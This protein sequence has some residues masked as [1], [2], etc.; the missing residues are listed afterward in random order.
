MEW[1]EKGHEEKQGDNYLSGV[2]KATG[3]P[4]DTRISNNCLLITAIFPSCLFLIASVGV[5]SVGPLHWPGR[6]CLQR[7]PGSVPVILPCGEERDMSG[8]AGT[9]GLPSG[10]RAITTA[11]V[12]PQNQSV[13]RPVLHPNLS[14]AAPGKA[15]A[16]GV[17]CPE[18]LSARLSAGRDKPGVFLERLISAEPK[19]IPG[20]ALAAGYGHDGGGHGPSGWQPA[21]SLTQCPARGHRYG[22]RCS[23][24]QTAG[25]AAPGE[26]CRGNSVPALL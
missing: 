16:A 14:F 7:G 15:K 2:G 1:E 10:D 19:A 24:P 4:G 11:A 21:A 9:A 18:A 12:S 25:K 26:L 13:K 20:V 8:T 5:L 3:I 6:R 22:H 17:G 23:P